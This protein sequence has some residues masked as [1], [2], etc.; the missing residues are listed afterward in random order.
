M[1]GTYLFDG[2]ERSNLPE[3]AFSPFGG[4]FDPRDDWL[5]KADEDDQRTAMEIWFMD[6]YCDPVNE[7]RYTRDGSLFYINGG[8]FDP[9]VELFNRFSGF[10]DDTVVHE[11]VNE[12]R[13]LHGNFWAR[14]PY[15]DEGALY[16]YDEDFDV[17]VR[18]RKD[19][20]QTLIRRLNEVR[21]VVALEGTEGAKYLAKKLAFSA[22][23]TAMESYFWEIVTF[24]V[25]RDDRAIE[26]IVSG[27]PHFKNMQ[28]FVGSLFERHRGIKSEVK[29]YLQ[30]MIWHRVENVVPL[31]KFGLHI[32]NIP[33][34]KA[35][36]MSILKRHDIVH[37]SGFTKDGE[38]I[39]VGRQE[40]EDLCNE[41][42]GVV[43]EIDKQFG[44]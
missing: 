37:R 19:P 9:E 42:L 4:P 5:E 11:V 23:I 3:E 30:S 17:N 22:A 33:S 6:H 36:K 25:E 18:N 24:S 8:P 28:M 35:L 43:H 40:I 26:R 7:T 41:I 32:E 20:L 1:G 10:V 44:P 15:F 16:S 12:M 31:L 29:A 27:I 34:F 13:S 14:R 2:D 38:A 39:T 21:D